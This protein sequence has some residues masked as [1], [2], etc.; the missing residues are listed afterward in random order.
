MWLT[1]F[2]LAALVAI[3]LSAV[4][5]ILQPKRP[6]DSLGLGNS[7]SGFSELLLYRRMRHLDLDPGAVARAEPAWFQQLEGR[8]RECASNDRCRHEL[9]ASPNHDG[10]WTWSDYCPNQPMLNLLSTLR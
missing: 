2:I 9:A 5:V 4:P 1:L 7:R 3:G 10:C 6:N 8:C